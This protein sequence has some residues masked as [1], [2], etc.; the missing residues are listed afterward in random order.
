MVVELCSMSK[1]QYVDLVHLATLA[2]SNAAGS[3]AESLRAFVWCSRFDFVG[4]QGMWTLRRREN[5]FAHESI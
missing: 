5:G 2:T 1:L 3:L 4:V